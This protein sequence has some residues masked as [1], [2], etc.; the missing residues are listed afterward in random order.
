[1]NEE[2]DAFEDMDGI[3]A[4]NTVDGVFVG[5]SDLSLR[6]AR[7]AYSRTDA[8][9]ADL[10]TVADAARRAG[11]PW[12]LPAWAQAEK[13]FALVHGADPVVLI[14]DHTALVAGFGAALTETRAMA[15]SAPVSTTP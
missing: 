12:V 9:F 11:K 6:R 13:E 8:D 10:L 3:L 14:A 4:L 7:G 5:P 15:E 2:A 1:M